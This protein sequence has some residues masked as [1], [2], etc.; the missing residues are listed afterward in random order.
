MLTIPIADR[1]AQSLKVSLGGQSCQIDIDQKSTGLFLSLYVNDAPIA[2]GVACR[3]G[4]R[5]VRE[6]YRGFIGDLAFADT[7]G[8]SDPSYPG[9]GTRFVLVYLETADLA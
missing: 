3:I 8:A 1:P 9:L 6:A 5:M 4:A 2:L 7:Q